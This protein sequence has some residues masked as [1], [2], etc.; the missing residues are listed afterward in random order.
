M[1]ELCAPEF[2][3]SADNSSDVLDY[4]RRRKIQA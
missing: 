2:L 3:D 4:A 1:P